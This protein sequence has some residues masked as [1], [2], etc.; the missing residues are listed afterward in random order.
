MLNEALRLSAICGLS[1]C[2]AIIAPDLNSAAAQ[3]SNSPSAS[4]LSLPIVVVIPDHTILQSDQ[5]RFAFAKLEWPEPCP[6][7]FVTCTNRSGGLDSLVLRT[8]YFAPELRRTIKQFW[9]HGPVSI[10]ASGQANVD[11][12]THTPFALRVE[13]IS[14]VY[15]TILSTSLTGWSTLGI[16]HLGVYRISYCCDARGNTISLAVSKDLPT[17]GREGNFLRDILQRRVASSSRIRE[18]RPRWTNAKPAEFEKHVSGVRNDL[19]SDLMR[20]DLEQTFKGIDVST[21]KEA[22]GKAVE[23]YAIMIMPEGYVWDNEHL[24][25]FSALLAA[26]HEVIAAVDRKF[27]AG[28]RNGDIGASIRTQLAAER[29]AQRSL[30]RNNWLGAMTGGLAALGSGQSVGMAGAE[31][32][33]R[34]NSEGAMLVQELDALQLGVLDEQMELSLDI[35]GQTSLV[36]ATSIAQLREQMAEIALK[37]ISN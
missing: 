4:P 29:D 7:M 15:P 13:Y 37:A 3:T 34:Q 23:Q 27:E 11:G 16:H 35:D 14:W 32:A 6:G 19:F 9:P 21:I 5:N 18:I 33:M 1:L 22:F 31:I 36:R 28:F 30:S 10:V 2:A 24:Y 26:E 12:P 20:R 25:L 8:A 17:S